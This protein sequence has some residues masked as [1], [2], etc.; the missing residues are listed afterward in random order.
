MTNKHTP[1]TI[2][3]S[4]K[5]Q[6]MILSSTGN[7]IAQT[8][9]KNR[10]YADQQEDNALLMAA[11]PQLA[12]VCIEILRWCD[13]L[14]GGQTIEERRKSIFYEKNTLRQLAKAAIQKARGEG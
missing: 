11:A 1:W 3:K 4:G 13:G 9:G 12:S 7:V 10:K 6:W 2:A 8:G 5:N 14:P